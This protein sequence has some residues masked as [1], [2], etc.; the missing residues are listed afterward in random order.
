MLL[1][2]LLLLLLL[3][4]RKVQLHR[5]PGIAA[6]GWRLIRSRC[7]SARCCHCGRRCLCSCRGRLPPLLLL[8]QSQKLQSSLKLQIFQNL[9]LLL[10]PLRWWRKKWR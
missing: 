1:L 10:L 7:P 9:L 5:R 2:L 6:K 3:E 4:L 8:L